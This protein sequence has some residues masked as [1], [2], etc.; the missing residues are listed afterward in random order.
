MV[1]VLLSK[2]KLQKRIRIRLVV[3]ENS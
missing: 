2:P 1:K 3:E